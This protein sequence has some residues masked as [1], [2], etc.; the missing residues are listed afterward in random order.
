MTARL[1]RGLWLGVAALLLALPLFPVPD[2][3]GAADQGPL[4]H[5]HLTAWALG[6]LLVVAV[7]LAAGRLAKGF[8]FGWRAS[9]LHL[10]DPVV[11]VLLAAALAALSAYTMRTVFAS[12]PHLVDEIAQLFHA[13]VFAT[14]RLA[15][16]PPEPVAAFL[17][18]HTWITPAGWASLYPPGHPA[19]LAAAMLVGAE[20]LVNPL[21]GGIG[22]PLVYLAARGLYGAPTARVAAVL[23]A[24]SAW[25]MFMSGT[26]MNHV[27]ATTL[28]LAGWA[29]VWA[30]RKRRPIHLIAAGF[31]FAA[32]TATRPLDGVAAALP[33]L[34]W[35]ALGRRWRLAPWIAFGGVLPAVAWGYINWRLYGNPLTMGYTAVYGAEI[36]LGFHVDPWGESFTPAVA[37]S[38][39]TV[40]VRRLHL[41]LYEWPIPALL[42]LGLW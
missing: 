33:V 41:Y 35:L 29:L 28:A 22:V 4:W 26:Y 14:G 1:A 37:L 20:W 42:P 24:V 30:P 39:L 12:N 21:L 19:I 36:G 11:L 23:W 5:P 32:V 27:T 34:V 38:N 3:T 15:A 31:C 7:G 8:H 9:W 17:V 2:W 18:P 25:V 10:R 6:V 16:P 13:R 40:A